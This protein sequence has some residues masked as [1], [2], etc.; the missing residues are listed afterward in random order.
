MSKVYERT[1][2]VTLTSDDSH[3]YGGN[4]P[5]F[6][7]RQHWCICESSVFFLPFVTICHSLVCDIGPRRVYLLAIGG[8]DVRST[9][10]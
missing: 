5:C 8:V 3:L 4:A 7:L 6:V 2:S 9:P 1:P 10:L